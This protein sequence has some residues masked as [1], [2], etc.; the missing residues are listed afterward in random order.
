[1]IHEAI[2]KA[3]YSYYKK[4]YP[5]WREG[6]TLGAAMFGGAD[7]IDTILPR[8]T[9]GDELD[10]L[11]TYDTIYVH[12]AKDGVSGIGVEL[13]IPVDEENGLGLRM[14]GEK[15]VAIGTAHEAFPVP[16]R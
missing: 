9:N 7:E 14:T 13:L 3:V 6:L 5:A 15:V 4:T 2:R 11:I 10:S 16:D 8:V 1:V 12:P